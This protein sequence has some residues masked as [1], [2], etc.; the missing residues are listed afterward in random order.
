[1][2]EILEAS[3]KEKLS[4][5]T[6]KIYWDILKDYNDEIIKKATIRCIKELKYFPKISEIIKAIEGT[7]EDEA[8]LAWIAFIEKLERIGSH[9][10]VTFPKYPAIGAVIEAMGGWIRISDMKI[11]EEKWVKKEFIKL[12]PIM[13]RRGDYPDELMGRF[14]LENSN[15][16][17]ENIMLEKYDRQLNGRKIDRK[18]IEEEIKDNDNQ[19]ILVQKSKI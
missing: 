5:G 9:Q 11:D 16:Y 15:K 4:K 1:M 14:E 12:Y 17:T 7:S 3:Y 13:K 2:I 18:K 10:T 19:K 6:S 8:E